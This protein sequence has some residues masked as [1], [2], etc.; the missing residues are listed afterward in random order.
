LSND[1]LC[2]NGIQRWELSGMRSPSELRER[3][4]R[5]LTLA[6]IARQRGD[7]RLAALLTERAVALIDQ[8]EAAEAGQIVPPAP[9]EA[10][11]PN[12]QR[13]QQIQPKGGNE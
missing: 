9:P 13:Q 8:A 5:V 3:A 1:V 12:V 4:A 11:Q 6:S 10:T 7:I 2:G